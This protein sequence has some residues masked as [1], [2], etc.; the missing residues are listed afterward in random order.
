MK[1]TVAVIIRIIRFKCCSVGFWIY[2]AFKLIW[3]FKAR[4]VVSLEL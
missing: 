3:Q 1:T 4:V 2:K